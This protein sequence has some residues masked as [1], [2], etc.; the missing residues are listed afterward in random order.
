[1]TF[2]L[3]G[4]IWGITAATLVCVWIAMRYMGDLHERVKRLESHGES[5]QVGVTQEALDRIHAA[6]FAEI[7][8]DLA[9]DDDDEPRIVH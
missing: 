2:F 9:D 7:A 1:M 6:V 8:A 4:A 5:A 3:I